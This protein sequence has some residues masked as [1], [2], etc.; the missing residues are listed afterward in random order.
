MKDKSKEIT[1]NTSAEKILETFQSRDL[2]TEDWNL[3]PD[4]VLTRGVQKAAET[5]L[6]NVETSGDQGNNAPP[7]FSDEPGESDVPVRRSERQTKN[8]SLSHY[9]KPVKHSVKFITSEHDITDLIKAALEAYR[10]KLATFKTDE[11]TPV[12]TKLG[13]LEKHLFRQKIGSEALEITK[14]WNAAWRVPLSFDDSLTE[15]QN[16]TEEH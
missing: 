12:E 5:I 7:C 4:Q 14:T 8:K 16:K 13:L 3:L 6:K 11:N 10:I 9:G 1:R 15:D 2:V